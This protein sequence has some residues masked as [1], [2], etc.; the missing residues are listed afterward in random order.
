[1]FNAKGFQVVAEIAEGIEGVDE[2]KAEGEDE[3][4]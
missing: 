3:A 2:G 1:M 4:E